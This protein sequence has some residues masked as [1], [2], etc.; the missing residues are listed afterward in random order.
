MRI[1]VLSGQDD[2]KI[3]PLNKNQVLLGTS[4]SCDVVL[5][6]DEVS[7]KH[8]LII[9]E[10]DKYYVIDQGSTNGTFL[11]DERL[12]PGRRVEFTSFF[13]VRLGSNVLITLLSEGDQGLGEDVSELKTSLTAKDLSKED[14]T[15]NISFKELQSKG[16]TQ[17]L[18]KKRQETLIQKKLSAKRSSRK[19]KAEGLKVGALLLG[20]ICVLGLALLIN[21]FAH[22]NLSQTEIQPPPV[23]PKTLRPRPVVKPID[24]Y[25]IPDR[26]LFPKEEFSRVLT[27]LKCTSDLEKYLCSSIEGM[28]APWGV[29][30][31]LSK[32]MILIDGKTLLN[33]TRRLNPEAKEEELEAL[34]L[35]S[36]L[37]TQVSRQLDYE[38]LKGFDLYFVLFIE[39]ES[40]KSASSVLAMR[41][42]SLKILFDQIA[43][44]TGI[45]DLDP[46]QQYFT[47]Y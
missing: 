46:H 35:K 18:I 32:L 34:A 28:T 23:R 47:I 31:V 15:R 1:E 45:Q 40:G 26:E 27:D 22:E 9:N 11:N 25:K 2:P 4:V 42:Q 33:E 21:F 14:Q 16:L 13:P 20:G 12:V 41:S 37:L 38:R 6:A 17:E 24:E 43:Q 19:K 30:Q 36:F 5:S 7:R 29:T 10:E 8:L 44:Q 3:Y 39:K